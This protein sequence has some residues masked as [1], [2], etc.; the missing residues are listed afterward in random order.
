M[1]S[2]EIGVSRAIAEIEMRRRSARQ[3]E[4]PSR[5]SLGVVSIVLAAV[6]IL[7]VVI[8]VSAAR[9][10]SVTGSGSAVAGSES[11]TG[12]KTTITRSPLDQLT[13]IVEQ[14][15]SAVQSLAESYWVPILSSKK[16]GTVDP[17]DAQFPN[18]A[19]TNKL[20]LENFKYWHSRYSSALL[21]RSSSYSSL[22]SGYWVII[23]NQR[24]SVPGAVISWCRAQGLNDD[25][26]DATLL[27]NRL[28]KGPQTYQSW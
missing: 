9:H 10:S 4:P 3:S 20:I 12:V 1:R 19:Y 7:G 17:R 6:T 5:R 13:A 18:K 21:L 22:F 15:R 16:I 25:D 24:Y 23:L 2:N 14:D 28:P 8:G 27:S 26:C 11:A